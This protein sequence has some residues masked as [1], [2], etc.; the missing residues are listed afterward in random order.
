ML[1]LFKFRKKLPQIVIRYSKLLDP[2]FIFYCQNN[3]DL[4]KQ[5]WN[6]WIPKSREK[7]DE[8]IK[9]FREEWRKDG[10]IIL[11][12]I[13]G[14][15]RLNFYRNVIPIYIVSGNAR[16]FSDPL[17]IRGDYHNPTDFVDILTHE[18][19]HVLFTDNGNK[20]PMSIDKNMF[21]TENHDT[22]V[23]VIVYAVLKYIYLEVLN[24]KERF[25]KYVST[26]KSKDYL[27]ALEIVE[28]RGYRELIEQF[29]KMYK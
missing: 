19:I 24:D 22:Q 6:D 28:K 21:P 2:I 10:E 3:P 4:K 7:I 17:I 29:V 20:V 16:N 9:L 23:H 12:G 18:L 25:E 14:I 5:G 13:C 8:N 11:R 26:T 15:L 27:R 1:H